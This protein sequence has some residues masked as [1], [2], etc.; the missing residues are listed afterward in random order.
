M[1]GR[2]RQMLNKQ[3]AD[4]CFTPF[5]SAATQPSNHIIR[6]CVPEETQGLQKLSP[7]KKQRIL[8]IFEQ[9]EKSKWRNK[10]SNTI[11]SREI[12]MLINLS[13]L[14]VHTEMDYRLREISAWP[15]L[16]VA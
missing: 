1:A 2:P 15:C 7:H 13:H 14:H 6:V 5:S 11:K 9:H 12:A 10:P 3:K 16:A 4:Q 8:G